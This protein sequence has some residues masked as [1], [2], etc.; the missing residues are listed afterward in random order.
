M[1]TYGLYGLAC[2]SEVELPHC[3]ASSGRSDFNIRYGSVPAALENVRTSSPVFQAAPGNY[4]LRIDGVGGFWARAGEEI[5]V[6]PAANAD[7]S[8]VLLFLLGSALTALLHQ[9][10]LL[11]LHGSALAGPKGAVL[12]AGASGRG[13]STITAALADRGYPVL[14]DD[15]A[16]VTL[17]GDAQPVIQPGIAVLKL[18]P[19][20]LRRLDRRPEDFSLV[21]RGLEKRQVALAAPS[22]VAIPTRLSAI[23]CLT[24]HPAGSVVESVIANS[25][26]FDMLLA[27]TKNPRVFEGLGRLAD[28]FR[29]ATS[30][31]ARVPM[32]SIAR[33]RGRETVSEIQTIVAGALQ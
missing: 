13:K 4:L 6:E 29:V 31:A 1:T 16:V 33:P 19:D 2:A 22:A 10:G 32:T 12:L 3:P 23:F 17:D 18:W 14:C 15:T 9:R 30:V 21:R 20:A 25:A 24:T 27:L 8:A 11:V 5:V 28:H 26:K 7:R